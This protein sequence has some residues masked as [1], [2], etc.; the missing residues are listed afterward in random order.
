MTATR[1]GSASRPV[2]AVGLGHPW[3]HTVLD[4]EARTAI[5]RHADLVELD[6]TTLRPL[7]DTFPAEQVHILVTGWGTAPLGGDALDALPELRLV[8]H[9]A[10]TVR[11]LVTDALWERG[12]RVSTAADANAVSVAD[13]TVAQ[14]QLSLKNAWRLAA[15]SRATGA[16][17]QR[18]EVRGIDGAVIGIVGLGR[19]GLL[20]AERLSALDVR[21]LAYD[22]HAPSEVRSNADAE[23]VELDD[24]FSRSDVVSLHAP[25]T[26]S[27]TGMITRELL[28]RMPQR[29]TLINTARG[30]LV[31]NDVLAEVL[32]QRADLFA[33]LDVT[34][35]EPL[36]D[37]HPLLT[38]PNTFVTPHIAGSLGTEEARLGALAAAEIERFLTGAPLLHTV[39]EERL[40]LSA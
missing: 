31:E 26:A 21:V 29:A 4:A 39:E 11:D 1:T 19:I 14:I 9:A 36:P 17:A 18:S 8:V 3:R 5:R 10:G 15:R 34:E 16:A 23:M 22:P 27:T 33:L 28:L 32:A 7:Q 24:L 40:A 20:V 38:L 30:A 13:F 6:P 37:R 25:L 35:P 2:V 12:I